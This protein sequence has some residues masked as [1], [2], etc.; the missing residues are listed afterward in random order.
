MYKMS[1]FWV[2]RFGPCC[3]INL[4]VESRAQEAAGRAQ[5]PWQSHQLLSGVPWYIYTQISISGRSI[6]GP[7]LQIF[8]CCERDNK[9]RKITIYNIQY[10]TAP[11]P[12]R[13][14]FGPFCFMYD[15][16]REF[17]LYLPLCPCSRPPATVCFVRH[18]HGGAKSDA[19]AL[20]LCH[21]NYSYCN[22]HKVL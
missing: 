10:S 12:H 13:M 8:G 9:W 1:V 18:W 2:S 22:H 17:V 6:F 15:R 7:G 20:F 4:E 19:K 5:E 21:T 3:E 14:G 11:S 16:M